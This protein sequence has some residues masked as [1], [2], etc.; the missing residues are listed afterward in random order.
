[1]TAMAPARGAKPRKA[2]SGAFGRARGAGPGP[3]GTLVCVSE[4]IRRTKWRWGMAVLLQDAYRPARKYT[5]PP[6]RPVELFRRGRPT[7]RALPGSTTMRDPERG[8]EGVVPTES[9]TRGISPPTQAAS[10]SR[11]R[12]RNR[13]NARLRFYRSPVTGLRSSVLA[14]EGFLQ[15]GEVGRNSDRQAEIGRGLLQAVAGDHRH[16]YVARFDGP[17][18]GEPNRCSH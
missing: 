4:G 12:C 2:E 1:M 13:S 11:Y 18:P 14:S 3:G 5:V 15:C 17:I 6:D 8:A 7:R 16:D 10:P 9:A